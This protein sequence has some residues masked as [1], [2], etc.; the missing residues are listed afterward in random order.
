MNIFKRELKNTNANIFKRSFSF[1][2][3][4]IFA[5]MLRVLFLK[6]YFIFSQET[7]ITFWQRYFTFFKNEMKDAML[8][9]Y[10]IRYIVRDTAF[11]KM[12]F[13][14]M[15]ILFSGVIYNFL[16]YLLFKNR[17]IGQMIAK[18]EVLN[19][20]DEKPRMN[21]FQKLFRSILTPLPYI[22]MSGL[23]LCA[24]LHYLNFHVYMQRATTIQ[25]ISFYMIEFSTIYI[26]CSFVIIIFFVWLNTYFLTNKFLLHD[27]ITHTRVADKRLYNQELKGNFDGFLYAFE[28]IKNI[29]DKIFTKITNI[30]KR[31]K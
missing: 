7:I 16:C 20:N 23:F 13:V 10:Q 29:L 6:I 31:E 2:M 25:N 11:E 5:N 19:N 26:F 28:K 4:L 3:D 22:A 15:I 18:L 17:T 14:V 21:I 8:K 27:I 24:F 30:I 9:D 1:L 12:F